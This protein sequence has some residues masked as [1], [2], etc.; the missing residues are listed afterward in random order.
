[1]KTM[2]FFPAPIACLLRRGAWRALKGRFKAEAALNRVLE[3]LVLDSDTVTRTR[4]TREELFKAMA[5]SRP[6][7]SGHSSVP[8]AAKPR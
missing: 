4:R 8:Y 6:T 7:S 2:K 1:M 3:K 5:A